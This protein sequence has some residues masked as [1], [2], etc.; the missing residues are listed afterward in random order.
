VASVQGYP[1]FE[2]ANGLDKNRCDII[3]DVFDGQALDVFAT[4]LPSSES[5]LPPKC[6]TARKLADIAITALS[7]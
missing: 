6:E 1:T 7:R 4:I 3:V 5:K 2:R